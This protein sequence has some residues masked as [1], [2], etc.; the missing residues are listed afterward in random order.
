MDLKKMKH[1]LRVDGDEDDALIIGMMNASKQYLLNA[2]VKEKPSDEL[3]NTAVM[4]LTTHFFENRSVD[5][6]IPA[7]LNNLVI[8]LKLSGD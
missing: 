4:M 5:T 8:Q 6:P 3:Y 7:M 1:Y 2:G